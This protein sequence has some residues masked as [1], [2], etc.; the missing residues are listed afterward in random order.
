MRW[1]RTRQT[2]PDA[3]RYLLAALVTLRA[4]G[5]V[6]AH[7]WISQPEALFFRVKVICAASRIATPYCLKVYT[8]GTTT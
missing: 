4:F 7:P 2:S 1:R 5:P 6:H 3:E 8:D